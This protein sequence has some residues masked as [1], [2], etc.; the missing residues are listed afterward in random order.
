MTTLLCHS[1]TDTATFPLGDWE[2]L[3]FFD[4]LLKVMGTQDLM[5]KNL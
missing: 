3:L 4:K 5:A 2:N 1:T